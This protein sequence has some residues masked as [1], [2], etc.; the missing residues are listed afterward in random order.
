MNFGVLLVKF[1]KYRYLF[2]NLYNLNIVS[3]LPALLKVSSEMNA[4]NI[5]KRDIVQLN[6]KLSQLQGLLDEKEAQLRQFR[7]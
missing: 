2:H 1:T 6:L 4:T 5:L 3:R 7:R